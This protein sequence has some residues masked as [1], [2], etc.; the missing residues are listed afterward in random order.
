MKQVAIMIQSLT[1][2]IALIKVSWVLKSIKMALFPYLSLKPPLTITI[3]MYYTIPWKNLRI[4]PHIVEMSILLS[5]N[6]GSITPNA[7]IIQLSNISYGGTH[8]I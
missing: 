8:Q 7:L 2:M 5:Y 6:K 3:S 4:D 1:S